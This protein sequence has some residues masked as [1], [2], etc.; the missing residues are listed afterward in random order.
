MIAP[1]TG[2]DRWSHFKDG[3][4]YAKVLK[5][6]FKLIIKISANF[7]ENDDDFIGSKSNGGY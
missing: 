7:Y 4:N 6:I 2:S 5:L 1:H 3:V